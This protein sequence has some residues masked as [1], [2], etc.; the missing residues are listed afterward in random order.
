MDNGTK[1]SFIPKKPLS[2]KMEKRTRPMS[3]LLFISF[4]IFFT[5]F[6]AY[7]GLYFYYENLKTVLDNKTKELEIAK[8]KADPT[9][10]IEKAEK[11]QLKINNTKNLLSKHVAPSKV[12]DLLEDT[13]LKSIVLSGFTLEK[14]DKASDQTMS[15]GNMSQVSTPSIFVIKTN[16]VAPSYAS[17]AYQS[18]ILN[19]EIEKNNRIESFSITN[20]DPDANGGVSFTLDISLRTPFLSYSQK[21]TPD[22]QSGFINE[23]AQKTKDKISPEEDLNRTTLPDSTS[24][25]VSIFDS[26]LNFFKNLK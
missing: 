2:R 1:V 15:K 5:T 24:E 13:T 20:L 12:F 14:V 25:E 11:L 10:A 22:K 21:E 6:V 26:V 4:F 18:D 8:E 23:R 17:L 19:K 3:L 7:G 16:G 9:G